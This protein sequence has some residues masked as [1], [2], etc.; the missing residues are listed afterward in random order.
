M[1][2]RQLNHQ[3][4]VRGAREKVEVLLLGGVHSKDR[5]KVTPKWWREEA[6]PVGS[7]SRRAA[8]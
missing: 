1:T 7:T 8:Q 5:I 3:D 4:L 6:A 2:D